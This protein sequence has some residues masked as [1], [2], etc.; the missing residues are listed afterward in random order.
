MQDHIA[1]DRIGTLP[2]KKTRQYLTHSRHSISKWVIESINRTVKCSSSCG[3]SALLFH[4]H[5]I[6]HWCLTSGGSQDN[7]CLCVFPTV[8]P[9]PLPPSQH[10]FLPSFPLG[11]VGGEV[12]LSV[13]GTN[14]QPTLLFSHS[15]LW[16][17]KWVTSVP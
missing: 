15:F 5:P 12:Q 8:L 1:S 14:G 13:V 16:T 4:Q 3:K 10:S 9:L 6:H 17:F 7:E 2:K 11:D